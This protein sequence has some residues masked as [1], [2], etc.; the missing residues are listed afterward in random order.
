VRDADTHFDHATGPFTASTLS[1]PAAPPSVD[2]AVAPYLRA[3][4]DAAGVADP[5]VKRALDRI[6]KLLE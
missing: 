1:L 5:I 2:R 6:T 3:F 4:P